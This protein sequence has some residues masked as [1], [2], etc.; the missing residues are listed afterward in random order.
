M[1][2]RL[3]TVGLVI[4]AAAILI[5]TFVVLLSNVKVDEFHK[6]AITFVVDSSASNQT[7]LPKQIKYIK[8]LCSIL[9]PEDAIKI[10]KTDKSSYLIYEGSPGDGV[11]ISNALKKYTV[12]GVD[13]NSYGEAIKKAVNYSLT[14][15]KNGYNTAIVVV[16]SL[17]DKGD[18]SKQINWET[19]PKNIEK[20]QKYLPEMAMMFVFA[21]PEK[22]DYVKTKLSPILG[23]NKLLTVNEVNLEKSNTRFIKAIGR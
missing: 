18:V 3:I 22:L 14:M 15:K 17:N 19:L 16:G 2:K 8:S 1:D 4:L 7:K 10:I 5:K 11:A 6:T 9:D 20:T 21:D 13:E 12:S 23:E